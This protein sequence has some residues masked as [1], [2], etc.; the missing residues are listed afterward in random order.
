MQTECSARAMDFGSAGGRQVVANFDGGL[1]SSDAGVLL[2]AETDK[3]IGLID[4]FTR[5]FVD[6]RS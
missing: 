1:V 5:C 6:R 2:L 3:A 4:R